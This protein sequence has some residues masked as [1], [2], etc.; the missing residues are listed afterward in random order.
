MNNKWLLAKFIP[1]LLIL[2]FDNLID[3]IFSNGAVFRE[4]VFIVSDLENKFFSSALR[5]CYIVLLI[6]VFVLFIIIAYKTKDMI[7]LLTIPLI[8]LLG[9]TIGKYSSY[10]LD[11]EYLLKTTYYSLVIFIDFLII[12]IYGVGRIYQNFKNITLKS[13]H[14]II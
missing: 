1:Y 13:I 4:Y 10:L 6:A 14:F 9:I 11:I 8:I 7:Y 12:I 2:F 5:N 3:I